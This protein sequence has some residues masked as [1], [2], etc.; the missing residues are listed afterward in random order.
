MKALGHLVLCGLIVALCVYLG[1]RWWVPVL[2][3]AGYEA[4]GVVLGF[5]LSVLDTSQ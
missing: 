3:I 5:A 1:A 2:W 4:L